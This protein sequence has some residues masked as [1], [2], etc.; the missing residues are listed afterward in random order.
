MDELKTYE[1]QFQEW[2][3]YTMKLFQEN[4]V[5]K[6]RL[7][8]A[9]KQFDIL[10]IKYILANRIF[11]NMWFEN[12]E[13]DIFGNEHVICRY[14]NLRKYKN[15]REQDLKNIFLTNMTMK[16]LENI[17]N[18][19]FE[20]NSCGM[21][22]NRIHLISGNI[23]KNPLILTI[24]S[25][26]LTFLFEDIIRLIWKVRNVKIKKRTIKKGD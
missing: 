10:K 11:G 4:Q 22:P 24:T 18:R 9:I 17:I 5:K 2:E 12:L 6:E 13:D 8:Y 20:H 25:R 26:D 3:D 14:R 15:Y 21:C 7:I 1:R 19:F 16:Q 23:D